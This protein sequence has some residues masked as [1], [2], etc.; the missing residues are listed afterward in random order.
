NVYPSGLERAAWLVPIVLFAPGLFSMTI[1][2]LSFSDSF[3][4][5][6]R[7]TVSVAPPGVYGTMTLMGLSG[8]AACAAMGVA[9]AAMTE[10]ARRDVPVVFIGKILLSDLDNH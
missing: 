5:T 7:V 1:G 9:R 2:C 10:S 4:I 3:C 8:Q 6:T